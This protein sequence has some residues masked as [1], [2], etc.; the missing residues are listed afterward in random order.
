M[1]ATGSVMIEGRDKQVAQMHGQARE[2]VDARLGPCAEACVTL[3][4]TQ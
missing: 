3:T 2:S 1:D 4:V